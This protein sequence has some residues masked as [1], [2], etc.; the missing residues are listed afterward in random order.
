MKSIYKI[1][2]LFILG[3]LL[4]SACERTLFID[5]SENE[6]KM[7]LNGILSP[8]SGLWLNVSE[9]VGASSAVNDSYIPV[10]EATVKIYHD[11]ELITTITEN[12][13]GNYFSSDF[14]PD[15]GGTYRIMVQAYGY[16]PAGSTV[17]IPE[18]VEITDFDTTV[19]VR[20]R[21]INSSNV[22]MEVDFYLKYFF[23][24]PEEVLNYYMLG[25]YY[26][27]FGEY[28]PINLDAD[29][30]EMNIYIIS[31]LE[32]L[33]FTDDNFNGES[34]EF[35]TQFTLYKNSGQETDI[36]FVLYSIEKDYFDYLKTYS[37]NFTVLND[38]MLMFEPVMVTSNIEGGYGIIS[39]VSSSSVRFNYTF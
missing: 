21:H 8:N 17:R 39:A 31:G 35:N 33:A 24:D 2:M 27:E 38:D 30:L 36:I 7:V 13:M 20:D 32:I 6:T 5:Y 9:S 10:E 12:K 16:P 19:V 1:T 29:H 3:L 25:A 37:Q 34:R 11:D 22:S 23:S 28:H 26:S 18:K 14:T 15:E 4:S